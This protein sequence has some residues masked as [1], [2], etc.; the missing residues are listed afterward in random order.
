MWV[1]Q[2]F[3]EF[4]IF[5]VEKFVYFCTTMSRCA[6]EEYCNFI[7]FRLNMLAHCAHLTH[8]ERRPQSIYSLEEKTSILS[9][10][11]QHKFLY[12]HYKSVKLDV[13]LDK[14]KYEHLAILSNLKNLPICT[15]NSDL[16]SFYVLPNWGFTD[17]FD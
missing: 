3:T 12:S 10:N 8:S 13:C 7:C 17:N 1:F 6:G 5:V 15:Q 14:M 11:W 4:Q 2:I 9:S 16:Q